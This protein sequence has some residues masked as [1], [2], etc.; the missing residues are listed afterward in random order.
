MRR[1]G[2]NIYKQLISKEHHSPPL[3]VSHFCPAHTAFVSTFLRHQILCKILF[4]LFLIDAELC[5]S[6]PVCIGFLRPKPVPANPVII[7]IQFKHHT[8]F[9]HV[10]ESLHRI[11][12]ECGF[13]CPVSKHLIGK[14]AAALRA[15]RHIIPIRNNH[16]VLLFL[17]IRI[18]ER[19][20]SA[21]CC[22]IEACNFPLCI[23]LH[24]LVASIVVNRCPPEVWHRYCFN[25]F[26]SAVNV[27]GQTRIQCRK[28]RRKVF[29]AYTEVPVTVN[30][31]QRFRAGIGHEFPFKNFL[32]EGHLV[33]GLGPG[34]VLLQCKRDNYRE[35]RALFSVY[36]CCSFQRFHL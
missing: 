23:P 18:Q 6:L 25:Q 20:F 30:H 16:T 31:L 33:P 32:S 1:I 12:G 29:A 26:F 27:G 3:A 8:E 34:S 5:T 11:I 10:A 4:N 7:C 13:D 22:C 24:H 28:H 21:F 9:R 17:H 15:G 14:P 19:L 35:F 36:G 2:E